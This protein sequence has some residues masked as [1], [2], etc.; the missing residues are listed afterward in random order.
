MVISSVCGGARDSWEDSKKGEQEVL[1]VLTKNEL[2]KANKDT[3]HKLLPED[4]RVSHELRLV[5]ALFPLNPSQLCIV[6]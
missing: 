4:F 5:C 2:D 1:V 6:L 3:H